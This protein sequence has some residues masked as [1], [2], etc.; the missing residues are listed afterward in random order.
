MAELEKDGYPTYTTGAGWLGYS[1]EYTR[2]LCR[3]LVDE[4]F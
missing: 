2:F 3:Q 1:E 4:G